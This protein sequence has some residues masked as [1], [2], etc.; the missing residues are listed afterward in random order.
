[1]TRSF[2]SVKLHLKI[3]QNSQILDGGVT[4][5]RVG[6]CGGTLVANPTLCAGL[7]Q[8]VAQLPA[9]QQTNPANYYLAAPANYYAEF[10]HQNA[11]NGKQHGFPYD[12]DN[13][14]SSDI[15]VTNPQYMVVAVGW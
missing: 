2:R 4:R 3:R 15:S 12:D 5:G 8:H 7:N 14:Q 1:L 10:W 9:A 11:I 13:G 6:G